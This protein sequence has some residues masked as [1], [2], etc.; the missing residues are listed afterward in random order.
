MVSVGDDEYQVGCEPGK[1]CAMCMMIYI[2]SDYRLPTSSW[3][4]ARPCFYVEAL[5]E[6]D[7][8]VRRQFTKPWIYFVGSHEG[9]GCGFQYGQY[10]GFEDDADSLAAARDSRKRLAEFLAAAL[11]H[12]SEVELFACWD[13]DQAAEPSRRGRMRPDSLLLDRAF[14]HEKQFLAVSNGTV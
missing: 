4:K 2:A 13:G 14:F 9:C 8:R 11:Q 3:S 1:T 6:R 7:E 5:S 10:V 12:Q